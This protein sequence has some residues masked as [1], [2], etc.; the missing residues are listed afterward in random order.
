[1]LFALLVMLLCESIWVITRL[2]KYHDDRP[3][4]GV[5]S[6][7]SLVIVTFEHN[8]KFIIYF[9]IIHGIPCTWKLF[10]P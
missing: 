4:L 1:M 2:L 6:E 8:I 3:I 10:T 9:V 7:P 5:R